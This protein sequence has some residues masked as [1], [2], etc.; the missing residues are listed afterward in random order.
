MAYIEN[1]EKPL[2]EKANI[3][4]SDNYPESIPDYAIRRFAKFL[5]PLMQADFEGKESAHLYSPKKPL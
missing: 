4:V 1:I 2:E 3:V 5:L